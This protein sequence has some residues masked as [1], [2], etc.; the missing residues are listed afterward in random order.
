V[1]ALRASAWVASAVSAADLPVVARDAVRGPA[2]LAESDCTL[3]IPPG[4]HAEPAAGGAL[5]LRRA[6]AR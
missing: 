6:D 4:W 5:V 3:W 1:I 2:V